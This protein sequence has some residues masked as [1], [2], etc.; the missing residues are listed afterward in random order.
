ME[1]MAPFESKEK[2]ICLPAISRID[3]MAG[4]VINP[5]PHQN[6]LPKLIERAVLYL[7]NQSIAN[8]T[9]GLFTRLAVFIS[10]LLLSNYFNIFWPLILK[11]HS[12]L[13][14]PTPLSLLDLEVMKGILIGHGKD[15]GD[16][17]KKI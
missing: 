11:I 8:I 7:T 14:K 2:T 9:N 6:S 16:G 10:H 4:M 17:M 1:Y 12:L 3:S 15:P 5:K 13:S